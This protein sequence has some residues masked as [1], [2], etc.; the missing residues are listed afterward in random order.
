LTIGVGDADAV[1]TVVK[2][3]PSLL[4]LLLLFG[5]HKVGKRIIFRLRLR[6]FVVGKRINPKGVVV[7]DHVV[8]VVG[9]VG[10]L[11]LLLHR[12]YHFQV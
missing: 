6:R 11:L 10:S 8:F 9:V 7:V 2:R 1:D 5:S 12:R 4:L 3:G